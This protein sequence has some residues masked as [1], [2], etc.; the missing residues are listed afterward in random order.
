MPTQLLCFLLADGQPHL[1]W[2]KTRKIKIAERKTI[3]PM[4]NANE[5]YYL[6]ELVC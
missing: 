1:Y 3:R 4:R 6:S 2:K 5:N